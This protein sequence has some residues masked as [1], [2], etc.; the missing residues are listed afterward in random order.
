MSQR[1]G[2]ERAPGQLRLGLPP[3]IAAGLFDLDGVLTRTA[4]LH[5]SA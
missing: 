4:I 5:A 2:A 3:R 1:A